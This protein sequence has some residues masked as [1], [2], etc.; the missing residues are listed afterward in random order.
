M[1]LLEK[2]L[3][4]QERMQTSDMLK[5]CICRICVTDDYAELNRMTGFA[6]DY[7]SILS[8]NRFLEIQNKGDKK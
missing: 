7:I 6:H 1:K 2:P 8:Y 3:T 4:P 5:G